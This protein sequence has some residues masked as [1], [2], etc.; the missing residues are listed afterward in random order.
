MVEAVMTA[1]QA[2]AIRDEINRWMGLDARMYRND[3]GTYDVIA[4][5][6]DPAQ[7]H[8]KIRECLVTFNQA[9]LWIADH[10]STRTDPIDY[11]VYWSNTQ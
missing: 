8:Q 1:A 9:C 7:P 5:R 11:T 3:A 6:P 4:A 2:R 10:A